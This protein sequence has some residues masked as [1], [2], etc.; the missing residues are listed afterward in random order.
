MF[1]TSFITVIV[2]LAGLDASINLPLVISILFAFYNSIP[3]Y[4]VLHYAYI[5]RKTSLKVACL[6]AMILQWVVQ[7]L[8]IILIWVLLPRAYDYTRVS[9]VKWWGDTSFCAP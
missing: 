1:L 8:A 9:W 6:I 2:G 7:V 3:Y 5:G 4:L